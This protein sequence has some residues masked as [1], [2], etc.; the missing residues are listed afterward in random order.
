M[1]T[2]EQADSRTRLL[3]PALLGFA[4]IFAASAD[5]SASLRGQAIADGRNIAALTDSVESGSAKRKL[6][7][8][9]LGFVSAVSVAYSKVRHSI[10]PW[11]TAVSLLFLAYCVCS[12][13][14]SDEPEITVRRI[15]MFGFIVSAT[16]CAAWLYTFEELI[17]IA[18]WIA[19]LLV[20]TAL[21]CELRLGTFTPWD[22]QYRFG[23]LYHPN[24]QGA[25]C[26]ILLM[27]SLALTLETK[28]WRWIAIS[29]IAAGLILLTKSRGCLAGA[30]LGAGT[31]IFLAS[32]RLQRIQ[33]VAVSVT[34][35]C[36][37]LILFQDD[38]ENT[39]LAAALL[40][41]TEMDPTELTGRS[42]LWKVC[43]EY[44][45][46]Q[47][48]LGYGFEAFWNPT[49]VTEISRRENWLIPNSHNGFV[50][51]LLSL[52]FIGLAIFL[53]VLLSSTV[54]GL[55]SFVMNPSAATAYCI[56][57]MFYFCAVNMLGSRMFYPCLQTF[58]FYTLIS[59]LA[60]EP[61]PDQAE[62]LRT[63][64]QGRPQELETSYVTETVSCARSTT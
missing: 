27:G 63:P 56:S 34:I 25:D 2:S 26:C 18:T 60:L 53:L 36:V 42:S 19:G 20:L 14:W 29:L 58:V 47:P 8:V 24:L 57:V 40:G 7:L 52:G 15:I 62:P 32:N 61:S 16:V 12:V 51:L 30:V 37:L 48:M 22:S 13:A 64:R 54:R 6:S 9:L 4:A 59:K 28:Q 11:L 46:Q 50:D 3:A 39:L 43:F 17:R 23:G 45:K 44:Q 38:L 31:L 1:H 55:R 35:G 21:I 41:R 49:R 10:A 33:L 5:P